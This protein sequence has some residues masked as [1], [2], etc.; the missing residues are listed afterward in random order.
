L[1][2]DP[3]G[4]APLSQPSRARFAEEAGPLLGKRCGDV[5][6]HGDGARPYAL[7]TPGRRR[8]DPTKTHGSEPLD[9]EEID[10]NWRAALGFLDAPRG[11]DTTLIRKALGVGGPGGHRGGA[12][13]E[14]PSDPECKAIIAWIEGGP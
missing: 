7:F 8:L 6:C 5:S 1:F 4:E 3:G 11:R 13:F 2:V 9:E 12:I 10:A 14:A